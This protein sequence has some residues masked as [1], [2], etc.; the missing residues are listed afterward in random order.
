MHK[1]KAVFVWGRDGCWTV[2]I[3]EVRGVHS[4]GRTI[5]QARGRVREALGLFV[6]D[7][8]RAELVDDIRVGPDVRRAIDLVRRAKRLLARQQLVAAR[9][10]RLAARKLVA[11]MGV[12]DAGAVLGVSYQR[13]AQ[14]AA[15][16]GAKRAARA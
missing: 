5:A 11:K 7:A 8:D 6:S 4:Q 15:S 12:R 1:Y 16:A 14:L 10:T 9:V 3:R 13:V 2:S